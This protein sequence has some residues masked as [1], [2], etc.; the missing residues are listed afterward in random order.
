MKLASPAR[1]SEFHRASDHA[2]KLIRPGRLAT[3]WAG[4]YRR[5]RGAH[6]RS[7]HCCRT[8]LHENKALGTS[9]TAPDRFVHTKN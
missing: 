6:G 8:M 4:K 7:R 1:R 3:D 2:P 9:V 5:L